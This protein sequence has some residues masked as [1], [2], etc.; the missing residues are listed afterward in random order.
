MPKTS[1]ADL[2]IGALMICVFAM[3]AI[4]M[5]PITLAIL[6]VWMAWRGIR[7]PKAGEE[8]E[9]EVECGEEDGNGDMRDTAKA[10]I[11]LWWL[12]GR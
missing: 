4:A 11:V 5:W 9:P 1:Y 12:F 3:I 8:S 6:V 10:A 2:F 7:G